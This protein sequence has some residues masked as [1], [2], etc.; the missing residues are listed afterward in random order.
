MLTSLPSVSQLSRK[1]WNLD[2]SQPDGSSRPV[3]GIALP[4][5]V[6][7]LNLIELNSVEGRNSTK[8]KSETGS[9]PWKAWIKVRKSV[10]LAKVFDRK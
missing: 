10:E 8:L 5:H 3:T 2:V 6:E 4:L 1:C 9:Q 7:R